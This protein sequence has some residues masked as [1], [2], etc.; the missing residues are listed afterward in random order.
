MDILA[1]VIIFTVPALI[2]GLVAYL[3]I[4]KFLKA[5]S[6]RRNFELQKSVVQTLT[7]AKLR[8]YERMVLFLERISPDS[9]LTRQEYNGLTVMQLQS[10]LLQQIRQEWE[11]NLS[12]QLYISNNSWT[13]LRSAKESMIQLINTCA[14]QSSSS[15]AIEFATLI[16]ETYQSAEKT[17]S[18]VALGLLK[19]DVA[20]LG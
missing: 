1:Q 10:N 20:R 11:H 19:T 4:D 17:P 3:L 7:P 16:I 8:A 6:Q 12:Q 13:M 18:Q 9:L 2:V 15:S 5:D 14:T